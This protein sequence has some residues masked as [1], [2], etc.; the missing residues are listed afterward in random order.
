MCEA[1]ESA[2]P[3]QLRV[4]TAHRNAAAQRVHIVLHPQNAPQESTIAKKQR[5]ASTIVSAY[6]S[7]VP[8]VRRFSLDLAR[9]TLHWFK[10]LRDLS[11]SHRDGT[12][13]RRAV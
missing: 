7:G 3:P 5:P 1:G 12:R 9:T 10:Q 8:W 13:G 2:C 11:T 6:L 4:Y